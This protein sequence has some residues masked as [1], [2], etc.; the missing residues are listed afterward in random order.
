MKQKVLKSWI[1]AVLPLLPQRILLRPGL[2]LAAARNQFARSPPPPV[3][4]WINIGLEPGPGI[5]IALVNSILMACMVFSLLIQGDTGEVST[6]GMAI[7]QPAV[8]SG[9]ATP[10]FPATVSKA[11]ASGGGKPFWSLQIISIY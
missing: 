2:I 4:I 5:I 9:R 8:V 10:A 3:S 6:P 7:S 1:L 11:A